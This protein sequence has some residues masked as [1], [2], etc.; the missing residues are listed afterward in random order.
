MIWE[1]LRFLGS[2]WT[3]H[4][5]GWEALRSWRPWWTQQE[6]AWTG[7]GSVIEMEHSSWYRGW[8]RENERVN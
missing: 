3:E 6:E 5:A 8:G 4:R 2:V 1:I 7:N